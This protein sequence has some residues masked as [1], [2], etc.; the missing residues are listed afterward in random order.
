VLYKYSICATGSYFESTIHQKHVSRF[1][2]EG[3][4]S[5]KENKYKHIYLP[6]KSIVNGRSNNRIL[7]DDI[8]ATISTF[9]GDGVRQN[10]KYLA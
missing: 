5:T 6:M 4:S 2:Q 9:K 1:Q 8:D 7:D 10:T 3:L